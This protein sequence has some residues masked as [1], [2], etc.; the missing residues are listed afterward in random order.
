MSL[1]F[2]T[3]QKPPWIL[4]SR[5]ELAGMEN[6]DTGTDKSGATV[7]IEAKNYERLNEGHGRKG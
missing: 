4:T 5:L 1:I 3:H 2:M 7:G 6:T